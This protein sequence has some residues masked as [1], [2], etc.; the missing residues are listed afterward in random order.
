MTVDTVTA[1]ARTSP[2]S[3]WRTDFEALP[4]AVR[5]EE[6][7]FLTQLSLRAEP[8][9]SAAEAAGEVVGVPLPTR[10]CTVAA[11]GEVEVLWLGPDEWLVVAPE[12]RHDLE[13]QL[14]EAV[15][16]HGTVV[17]VSAQR[18][19][20]RLTGPRA[21]TLLAHGCS[22]DLHPR[23]NLA[24]TCVQTHLARAGVIL[25]TRDET[26][27]DYWLIVRSSFASYLAEWL[28]DACRG[29]RREPSWQ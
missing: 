21:R 6:V 16:E 8:G 17:D 2:L 20:L 23:V 5:L 10:A 18:T 9:S 27:T 22:L 28:V 25:V 14:R 11:G 4:A 3:G 19:T 15:G 13:H 7:A 29:H 26:G 1:P 24:G 12:G